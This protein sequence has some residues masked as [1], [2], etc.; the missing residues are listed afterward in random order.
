MGFS[1]IWVF[2]AGA[3]YFGAL[4]ARKVVVSIS[5]ARPWDTY[6]MTLAVAGAIMKIS[7][8]LARDT[9]ST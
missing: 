1:Y 2:M 4:Q 8:C 5:S 9:C 3:R 7:A 6:A